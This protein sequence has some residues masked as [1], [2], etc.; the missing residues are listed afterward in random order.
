MN[1][2][3]TP[4]VAAIEANT[5]AVA[6]NTVA[7]LNVLTTANTV[8]E[9][10]TE[11]PSTAPAEEAA[12]K[13]PKAKAPA[14]PVKVAEP[15]PEPEPTPEP[16]AP[17]PAEEVAPEPTPEPEVV[18]PAATPADTEGW[19][20]VEDELTAAQLLVQITET[21][22][23]AIVGAKDSSVVKDKWSAIRKDFGVEK[24][25]DLTDIDK[26]KEA[27]VAAKTL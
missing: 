7:L 23:H 8:R 6:A 20:P 26:L 11:A 15:E 4:L 10:K 13:T 27:L 16:E 2:D 14:K 24:I 18:A 9:A 1:I 5:A 12:P 19:E 22:K 17:A 21:V 3:L 25:S